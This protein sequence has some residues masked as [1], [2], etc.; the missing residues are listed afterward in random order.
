MS[1]V[2]L[3]IETAFEDCS[4]ECR[5]I[6]LEPRLLVPGENGTKWRCKNMSICLHAAQMERGHHEK[7]EQTT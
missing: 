3:G 2:L 5:Y 6:K 1:E 4:T 7:T